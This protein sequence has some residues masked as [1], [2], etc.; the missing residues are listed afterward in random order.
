MKARR[1]ALRPATCRPASIP[2]LK[3]AAAVMITAELPAFAKPGQRH[4]HHRLVDG[5]GQV[6]ARRHADHDA[7]AWAPT[8]RSMRWR[9]ATSRSAASASRARTDRRSSVNVPSTGRIPDGATVERAVATGFDTAPTLT[10]NLARVGLHHR[11]ERR[12]G[13]QHAL[14]RRRRARR[15]TACRSRVNAPAGADIRADDDE[16][17]RESRRRLRRAAGQGDR[18][19]AHRHRRDQ[20]GASASARPRS[21]TAS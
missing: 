5:Q 3:N 21:P 8:A 7:A 15:S 4:R 10:F 11:A 17:D 13:D 14:R 6:A 2:A 18:Q 12:R 1:L 20:L 19:R 16:R 9:R